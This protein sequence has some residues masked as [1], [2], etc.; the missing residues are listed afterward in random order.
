MDK[1]R[2]AQAKAKGD[3]L[4]IILFLI[5]FVNGFESG[6]YQASLWSIGQTYDLSIT[7]MGLFAAAEL[8]ADMLA[9]ILLGS[10]ADRVGKSM[11]LKVMLCLQLVAT[12]LAWLAP[13]SWLFV[14]GMFLLGLTTSA[15]QFIAIAALAD[16]Y[17][18][19]SKR[20]IGYI[21]SMYAFGAVTSPLIVSFYLNH[22]ISW[23]ALF[24][25]LWLGTAVAL[26]GIIDAGV[27]PREKA[28]G[29]LRD[30]HGGRFVLVGILL[31]C[32]IMCI[33][34][35]FENGFAFFVDT[36]FVDV[37][38][39]S[40]GKYA[41]SLYWAVMIPSR[42]L[43]G[44]F[45]EKHQTILTVSVIAIPLVTLLIAMSTSAWQVMVL[46]VPL[47]LA[48]GAIYPSVLTMMLPFAGRKTA[49]A[50]G[51]IT[52]ATGIGGFA[53]TALTG[54]MADKW[55]M[56]TAMLALASFFVIALAAVIV[57]RALANQ[58]EGT[59]ASTSD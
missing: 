38:K 42:I 43:V 35:G 16:A 50:T 1:T 5:I 34:V 9:P 14:A 58:V 17:P 7:S 56:Q 3:I 2:L 23:K 53:L 8:L 46:C 27:E 41:L 54:F 51:M 10:W 55:G 40:A 15:L 33:Y 59:G 21:T 20:K 30:G 28:P 31:L 49:T 25:F 18:V 6:G 24:I 12:A 32:V 22:G 52:A 19:S 11:S 48:S 36:L 45:S 47:G 29:S 39:S 13:N 26:K 37:F 57:V 44:R 4:W